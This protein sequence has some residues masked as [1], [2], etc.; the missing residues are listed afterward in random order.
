MKTRVM[1]IFA[2]TTAVGAMSC[3]GSKLESSTAAHGSIEDSGT[4]LASSDSSVAPPMENVSV[5]VTQ[6]ERKDV[7]A[8]VDAGLGQFLQSVEIEP[9]LTESGAFMGFRIV[10]VVDSES[11][12]GLGIGAGDVVTSINQHPI[13]RPNE[14]Y[15]A[16]VG[17]RTAE[18]LDIDYLRG[19]RPMRLSLPIV[20]PVPVDRQDAK[21]AAATE[22]S[23]ADS[24]ASNSAK[25]PED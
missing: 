8:T 9:S 10:R 18:R 13:E 17:L 24:T 21:G 19:G 23:K 7:I 2:V 11:F 14:A 22:A 5:P 16:F 20:G 4:L 1:C 6:L 15:E 12:R 25:A 3:A